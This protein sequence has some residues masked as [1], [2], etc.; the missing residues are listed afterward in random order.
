[1]HP[2]PTSICENQQIHSVSVRGLVEFL[3]QEGDLTP[4]SFQKRNRAQAGTQGHRRVQRSRPEGY[5]SEVEI[6]F[7]IPGEN[8]PIEIR[9]RIDGLDTTQEPVLIEEIKTTTLVLNLVHENHNSLHWAQAKCYAYIFAQQ[10]N[11]SDIRIHLTYYQ[12]DSQT[13]KTFERDFTVIELEVFFNALVASYL[14]WFRKVRE[15]RI[16]RDQ[17]IQE[18]NFPYA[19]YRPG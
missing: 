1:M 8:P 16:R 2:E 10:E 18:L 5:Q 3:L 19:D 12:L 7:R 11:L 13:E 14:S 9:G 4:G 15:R 17:T 6:A